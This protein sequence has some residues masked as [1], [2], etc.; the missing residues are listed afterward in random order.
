LTNSRTVR[1]IGR[2]IR[3]GQDQ[4]QFDDR[5]PIITAAQEAAAVKGFPPMRVTMVYIIIIHL[6]GFTRII[7]LAIHNE[8]ATFAVIAVWGGFA[9]AIPPVMQAGVVATAKQVAPD[10][11]DTAS[12]FNI[13]AFNL[14]ISSGSLIGGLLLSGPGPLATPY[15]AIAMAIV[16]LLIATAALRPQSATVDSTAAWVRVANKEDQQCRAQCNT[17]G[18]IRII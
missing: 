13:A 7:P 11:L 4:S 6:V 10:A 18:T 15:A 8:V 9:F 12:G 16:A 3:E 17:P 2:C 14:G 1:W 5:K